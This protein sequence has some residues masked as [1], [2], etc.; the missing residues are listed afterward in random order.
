MILLVSPLP[1]PEGGIAIWTKQYLE[2]CKKNNIDVS[3]VNIALT[4]KRS[5]RIN[6]G[7]SLFDEVKRTL[8]IIRELK[9]KLKTCK[10]EYVHIN[11]ACAKWGYLRDALCVNIAEKSGAKVIFHYRCTIKDKL[12][13]SRFR[14]RLFV[15][16]TAKADLVM[17]LNTVSEN[18]VKN[19][20][21]ASEV[22]TV[23]NFIS[24]DENIKEFFVS[25]KVKQILYVGHVQFD[26]G[27]REMFDAAK[28]FPDIKFV[29]A[30][31][32]AKEVELLNCPSNVKLL[33][34][35]EHSNV[36]GLMQESD[37]FLFPSYTEGF[38]NALVEAMACG[39]PVIA[40]DVGA[41]KDMI[42][43]S[44]GIIVSAGSSGD[45]VNAINKINDYSL[46][47]SMSQWNRKKVFDKYRVET[48]MEQL[49]EL[50]DGI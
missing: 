1:P 43:D 22:I 20:V 33:G 23:P 41:N 11:T 35:V 5:N 27:I 36:K 14:N 46:R 26:K 21:P 25:D 37:V 8:Y 13:R 48:V 28:S 19:N 47:Y 38:S 17:T 40:T 9:S 6:A 29:L 34:R 39:M 32:V 30:G 42:E 2:Y 45:I 3:I 10:P 44:G 12:D 31:P 15:K 50:Y 49:L 4:G 18:F 16:T 24:V 7:R